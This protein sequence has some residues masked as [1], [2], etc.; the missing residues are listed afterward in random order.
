[1]PG[2]AIFKWLKDRPY[3]LSLGLFGL[4]LILA[5]V[6]LTMAVFGRNRETVVVKELGEETA[7]EIWV[8][9]AGAVE[10]PGVYKLNREARL[11]D[12]L[13]LAGGLA[14]KADR[15]WVSRN[16]N[17]AQKLVDGQKIFVPERTTEI[18]QTGGTE[19]KSSTLISINTGTEKE[20]ESLWGI[21]PVT[22]QKIIDNRPYGSL[23]ELLTKKIIKQNVWEEIKDKISL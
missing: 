10:Q 7:A 12:A 11:N 19:T 16:L 8:D 9:V 20:L 21:G 18:S 14:A 6:W 3:L 13:V 22:A 15:E 23:D 5:G 17:L 2:E 4:L 1:M